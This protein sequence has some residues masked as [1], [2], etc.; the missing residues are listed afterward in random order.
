ML[1]ITK[2]ETWQDISWSLVRIRCWIV[3]TRIMNTVGS[4]AMY[5]R[6]FTLEKVVSYLL[7]S[8]TR[9]ACAGTRCSHAVKVGS[10]CVRACLSSGYSTVSW[11]SAPSTDP[12]HH[13]QHWQTDLM[14]LSDWRKYLLQLSSGQL[15][16]SSL[17]TNSAVKS[18]KLKCWVCVGVSNTHLRYRFLL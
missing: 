2:F 10:R 14:Y 13:L 8:L 12:S 4:G 11:L 6:L 3:Y 9:D 15:N 7:S 1:F 16:S 5:C 17:A 18:R